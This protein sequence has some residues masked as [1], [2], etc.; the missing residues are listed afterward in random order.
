MVGDRI[1]ADVKIEVIREGRLVELRL[2][3]VELELS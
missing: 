3:P 1:G 2:V